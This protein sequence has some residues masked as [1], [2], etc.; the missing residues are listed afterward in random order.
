MF[1]FVS[2]LVKLCLLSWMGIIQF[3]FLKFSCLSLCNYFVLNFCNLLYVIFHNF[4][5]VAWFL[6]TS[7]PIKDIYCSLYSLYLL[8]LAMNYKL[9]QMLN[10]TRTYVLE[11]KIRDWSNINVWDKINHKNTMKWNIKTNHSLVLILGFQTDSLGGLMLL[12]L[13]EN[14]LPR[15]GFEPGSLALQA[16]MFPLVPPKQIHWARLEI[17]SYFIPQLSI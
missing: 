15:P 16:G 1:P 13:R 14:L 3:N 9:I 5:S 4:L 12:F 6:L 7:I 8:W 17:S 11:L 2:K 10:F